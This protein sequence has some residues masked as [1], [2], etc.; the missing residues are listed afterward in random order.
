MDQPYTL[1]NRI[2]QGLE[3]I[4]AVLRAEQWSAAQMVGLNPTQMSV[5]SFLAGRGVKG[6]KVKDIANHFGVSQPSATDTLAALERKGCVQKFSSGED[7]RSTLVRISGVGQKFLKTVGLLPSATETSIS[8]LPPH[9][10][11]DLLLLVVKLIRQ[12]QL[13]EAIPVQRMCV[14]CC[15]FRPHAHIG[16]KSP[17]HCAFVNAAFGSQ[18]LRIECSDHETADPAI[19]TAIWTAFTK[20]SEN[21][22]AIDQI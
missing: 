10:Q 8:R 14:S 19:Q 18:E 17:H 2:R 6:I 3:R 1:P 21:L 22:Q 4:S 20:G 16:E 13:A 11:A 9:E 5:L 12:F 15:H 7:A